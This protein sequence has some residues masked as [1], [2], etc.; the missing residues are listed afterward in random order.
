MAHKDPSAYCFMPSFFFVEVGDLR[1]LKL[2][3]VIAIASPSRTELATANHQR[4]ETWTQ[5][6]KV[7]NEFYTGRLSPFLIS[8]RLVFLTSGARNE[9]ALTSHGS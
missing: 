9:T 7:V 8:S 5:I 2:V 6:Q 3:S 4:S 1:G